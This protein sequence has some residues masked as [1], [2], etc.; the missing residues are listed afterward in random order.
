MGYKSPIFCLSTCTSLQLILAGD[1]FQL[2]PVLSSR[3]AGSLGL[4]LSL[5]ERVMDREAYLRDPRKFEDH[6]SYDPL[7]VRN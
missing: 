1:P 3:L 6:G 7:M 5:L 4:S 2:G